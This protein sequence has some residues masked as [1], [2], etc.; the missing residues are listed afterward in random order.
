MSV[1]T[2]S[3]KYKISKID[4]LSIC[5]DTIESCVAKITTI[6][7]DFNDEFIVVGVYRPHT[8]T[9]DNFVEALHSIISNNIL[10]NKKIFLAGDMN[11]D[12]TAIDNSI[13]DDYLNMLRSMN[14]LPIITEPTRYPTGDLSRNRPSTLDH[15]FFNQLVSFQA[16][17]FMDDI[18]DH[19]GSAIRIES[20][21]SKRREVKK[22]FSFRP[23]SNE[24]L[25]KLENLILET[26]WSS[27]LSSSDV[28][29]QLAD[30]QSYLDSSYCKCFP[31]KTKIIGEKRLEN[32]WIT[33]DIMQLIRIKSDY[34]KMEKNGIITKRENNRMKNKLNKAI[35]KAKKLYY[36]NSFENARSNMK[37]SWRII[38]SLTGSKSSKSDFVKIFDE[39]PA[40]EN[41]FDTLNRFNDFF[42]SIGGNLASCINT[43]NAS[44]LPSFRQ[45]PNSFYLFPP[46]YDEIEHIVKNLKITTTP[47]NSIPVKIFKMLKHVLV[48]P[49][50]TVI[51]NSFRKGIF[52]ENFKVARVT[53][54]HKNGDFASANNFRPISSLPFLSKIYEKIFALRLMNFFDKYNVISAK[55]FGFQSGIST[56]DA[57]INLTEEIYKALDEKKP[58]IA[59]MLDIKKAFDCVDHSIL[60]RKLESY[61][62]RGL[63]L[64]WLRSYLGDRKCYIEIN[65]ISSSKNVFN[66][67]VPQGSILGPALFLVHINQLPLVSNK[68]NCQMFADDTI[69]SY[70]GSDIVEVTSTVTSELNKIADWM[71]DN[72]L[73][74]NPCKTEVLLVS[75]RIHER[76]DISLNFMNEQVFCSSSAKYLGVYL[77]E[78]LSFRDH[79]AHVTKKIARHTGILYKIKEYLPLKARLNYY[80]GYIY[81]YLNY[82]ILIW[83]G[84]CVSVLKPLITQQKRTIRII[85]DADYYAHTDPLFKKLN[86]LKI[87]DIYKLNL[88]LHVHKARSKG[89]L[90]II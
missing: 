45:N 33:G 57:L 81:P 72:K 27:L 63:P 13:S 24:N 50:I 28:N 74:I 23:F 56:C 32:P 44:L 43:R 35:S 86:I 69:V 5:N 17:I 59:A 29:E 68:L 67:G 19:C 7:S 26:N 16:I 25:S 2:D 84:A 89:Y 22:S 52:P 18:S 49:L 3:N 6:N 38:R 40:S 47:V 90:T 42:S 14:F 83:G 87:E 4:E 30:F 46:N 12:L 31:L 80:F 62:V 71:N 53:P 77:D 70:S 75:N 21:A 8:D 73:T 39:A 58:Y 66:I 1:F 79:I 55:Q 61:G 76:S 36:Q 54:I 65:G 51:G 41:C 15:I 20:Y 34:F 85:C 82:N 11:V 9:I 64:N 78:K 10:C 60:L 37:K 48:D 88:A